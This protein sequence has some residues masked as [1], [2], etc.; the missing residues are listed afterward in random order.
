MQ[1]RERELFQKNSRSE[2]ECTKRIQEMEESLKAANKST[3]T[4]SLLHFSK[5]FQNQ[6]L[7]SKKSPE[8]MKTVLE[9]A[10]R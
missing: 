5:T 7:K 9:N 10:L 8:I 1:N 2:E 3:L 6:L 4:P